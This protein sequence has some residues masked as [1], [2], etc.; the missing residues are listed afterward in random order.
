MPVDLKKLEPLLLRVEKPARYLGG[1][2]NVATK[3]EAEVSVR[4]CLAFPDVYDLGMS[5]HGYNLLYERLNSRDG[6]AAERA[7]T[8]WP[9][10]DAMLRENELPLFSLESRRALSEFDVVGFTL[11]HEVN[12]TNILSML[13]LGGIPV[14][15]ADRT[16]PFPLV[17][18]GGEGAYAPEVMAPFFDAFV[19][20]DGE[21]A[22][23]DVMEVAE[24][25]KAEGWD[26]ETFLTHLAEIAGVYIPE[27]YDA[28]YK[29]DGTVAATAPNRPGIPATVAKR[30]FNLIEDSGSVHPVVPLLRTVHDRFA[31]EI[32]RGCTN[33]CR[34]CQAGMITRPVR[35]RSV[36]QVFEIAREG[37]ENT[38]YDEIS[39]LSLSSAD[40]TSIGTLVRR[41]TRH[42]GPR[43][44]SVTLPSL[45]INAFDV[46]L[47]DEIRGIRK[48]GFT[49]APEAGTAR[50][51]RV[52]NKEVDQEDF[53]RIIGEVFERGWQTVKFYFMLGLPTETQEDLD[54]IVDICRE[55]AKIGKRYHGRKA[56]VNVTLS[57]FVPKSNTPFQWE[58]QLPESEMRKRYDYVRRQLRG[59]NVDIKTSDTGSSFIEAALARGDRRVAR[60]IK[61][62]WELGCKFDGWGEYFQQNLWL[63]AFEEEGL[64]PRF[65]ANR[66]RKEKEVFSFDH[67]DA[68]LGKRFLW[69]DQRRAWRERVMEDCAIGK[70]AGCVACTDDIEH[71]LA[72]DQSG[73]TDGVERY[74]RRF[75]ERD[76]KEDRLAE[77]RA[78]NDPDEEGMLRAAASRYAER[79]AAL[80]GKTPP[81]ETSGETAKQEP[82]G[83]AGNG[84]TVPSPQVSAARSAAPP[85]I[86]PSITP[87]EESAASD[88]EQLTF[89]RYRK[90]TQ[91][92]EKRFAEPP[93]VQRLRVTYTKQ[94][95]LRYLAHLDI[96]KVIGLVLRRASMPLSYS[97]GY[98]SKPR[99][100][101]GPPLPLGVG[102]RAEVF[103]ML[104]FERVE[105]S[106]VSERLNSVSIAGLRFHDAEELEIG[107]DSI[108]TQVQ[109]SLFR[110]GVA[111]EALPLTLEEVG[112]KLAEFESAD[113]LEVTVTRKRRE[114]T[115]DVRRSVVSVSA[116][117]T[118]DGTAFDLEISHVDGAYIKPLIAL[119]AILDKKLLLGEGVR[120]ERIELRLSGAGVLETVG[121]TL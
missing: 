13:D 101:H 89:S 25:A 39:L 103:D 53:F 115:V 59:G 87:G 74:P 95:V 79:R 61:R 113:S 50:L 55:A 64:D 99:V 14:E 77:G 36:D 30:H 8:P 118:T 58:P 72:K 76:E 120:V 29:E 96:A 34:F 54:G 68:N 16:S 57:P 12:Y 110:I 10:F 65:Y 27:F 86:A 40:Y 24:R 49:F 102:G 35:E 111:P 117:S 83:G 106:T 84:L 2:F 52:I 37:I 41:L 32:R 80:D 109:S 21:A 75:E 105:G 114:K 4:C 42:F 44:I 45:R 100:Q 82:T 20:G 97:E 94:G 6:W 33:G 5:Y 112:E 9:D 23:V 28:T 85:P 19:I 92:P 62:A 46:D 81:V 11:Q 69:A 107:A 3:P 43:R 67:I 121:S 70:C 88:Q 71:I 93:R 91:G 78:L 119:S 38:G 31:I 15:A 98:N 73:A 56:I 116:R 90:K 108:E 63:Q 51:R 1:E 48:S 7:F 66:T 47:A 17:L 18:G 26:R 104:L 22:I 60:V